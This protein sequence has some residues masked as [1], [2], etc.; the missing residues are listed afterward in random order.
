MNDIYCP[1]ANTKY[2]EIEAK[3]QTNSFG[4]QESGKQNTIKTEL[5]S[6]WINIVVATINGI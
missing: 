6:V 4:I 1:R 3:K 2:K 5:F